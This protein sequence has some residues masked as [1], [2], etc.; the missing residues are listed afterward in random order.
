[1]VADLLHELQE[2]AW[3]VGAPLRVGTHWRIFGPRPAA[4][5]N[6]KD[7]TVWRE[8]LDVWLKEQAV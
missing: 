8:G 2:S 1:E 3:S 7:F 5:R 4:E 6:A